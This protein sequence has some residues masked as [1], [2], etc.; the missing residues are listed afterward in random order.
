M[1]NAEATIKIGGMVCRA[2]ADDIEQR[3]F[4]TAGVV[5]ADVSYWRAQARVEYAPE[6]TAPETIA[7]SIEA[8]GYPTGKNRLGGIATDAICVLITALLVLLLM[9]V[10]SSEAPGMIRDGMSFGYTFLLGALTSTH[11]ICMCGGIMLSQTTDATMLSAKGNAAHC[12]SASLSYNGA[13]L[14]SYTLL[15]GAF[16]ALGTAISYGGRLK[17]LVFTMAGLAVA[18]L[19]LRMWG[20][21]PEL[22]G[23]TSVCRQSGKTQRRLAGKPAAIGLLTGLMPCGVLYAMWIYSAG[24]GSAAKGALSMLAFG[25]GTVPLMLIFG[26][27][28]SF[29]PAK[30]AKY[31]LRAS[32]MLV[33]AMGLKMLL[34]GLMMGGMI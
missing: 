15:G 14:L 29:I 9:R 3:L 33:C 17:S 6:L 5:S 11:C 28:N 22:R 21:L 13:R 27:L 26:A 25:L 31:M 32:A 8:I 23:K 30:W 2:C 10:S 1:Q 12:R 18:L 4:E 16:G 34:K 20:L 24:C 7:Q 19:G